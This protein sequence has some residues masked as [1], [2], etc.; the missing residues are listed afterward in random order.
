MLSKRK[1]K[2]IFFQFSSNFLIVLNFNKEYLRL[3]LSDEIKWDF[4]QAVTVTQL[5]YG[6]TTRMLM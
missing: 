6:C 4:F 5:L 3:D 1:Y 2:K